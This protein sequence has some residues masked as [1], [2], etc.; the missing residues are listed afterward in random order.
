MWV[1]KDAVL[2]IY[3][4]DVVERND[5]AKEEYQ[6]GV[7]KPETDEP[8]ICMHMINNPLYELHGIK[9]DDDIEWTKKEN[10]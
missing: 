5:K 4:R 6:C 2:G 9:I 7:V 1:Y 3:M 10:L 8:Y